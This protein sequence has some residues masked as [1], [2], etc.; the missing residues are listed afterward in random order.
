LHD[1]KFRDSLKHNGFVF[2]Q[3]GLEYFEVISEIYGVGAFKL[4]GA[5]MAGDCSFN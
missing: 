2:D 4:L 3:K 5:V 1:D